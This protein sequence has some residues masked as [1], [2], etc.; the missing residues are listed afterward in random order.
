MA[1]IA[2]NVRLLLG[3]EAP[4]RVFIIIF[5]VVLT[6]VIPFIARRIVPYFGL[7]V[8]TL[9]VTDLWQRGKEHILT[10]RNFFGVHQVIETKDRTHYLLLNGTTVH[11]LMRVRDASG[12]AVHGR[13]E[14][15]YN[16]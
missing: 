5:L 2:K 3:I 10:V 9:L 11:G 16:Y 4:T 15:S 12:I 1:G 14:P 7:I 13:P 8:L 6:T